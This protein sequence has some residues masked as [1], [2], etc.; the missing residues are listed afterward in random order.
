M[1]TADENTLKTEPVK[2]E[3]KA[4]SQTHH[5]R[6]G[7]VGETGEHGEIGSNSASHKEESKKENGE[8]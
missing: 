8:E 3:K 6:C 4:K 5:E 1:A 7:D 2:E